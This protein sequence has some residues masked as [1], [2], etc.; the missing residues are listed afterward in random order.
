MSFLL[1]YDQQVGA[2][3][4]ALGVGLVPAGQQVGVTDQPVAAARE[5][6][7]A[8]G[9]DGWRWRSGKGLDIARVSE[10]GGSILRDETYPALTVQPPL[11]HVGTLVSAHMSFPFAKLIRR[12]LD[13][14]RARAGL[15]VAVGKT[16][17]Q[18]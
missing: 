6:E 3:V 1:V 16:R 4:G 13:D 7:P 12:V 2:L 5:A 11:A 14:S 18:T 8:G 10:A 9:A 17:V 15:C